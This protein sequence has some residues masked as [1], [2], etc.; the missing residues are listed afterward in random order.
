MGGTVLEH[1]WRGSSTQKC[2]PASQDRQAGRSRRGSSAEGVAWETGSQAH[3]RRQTARCWPGP[4]TVCYT[5]IARTTT[6]RVRTQELAMPTIDRRHFFQTGAAALFGAVLDDGVRHE[7]V[8]CDEDDAANDKRD[9]DR[10]VD[11]APVRCQVCKPPTCCRCYE[12]KY[13]CSDHQQYEHYCHR[14]TYCILISSNS[15]LVFAAVRK[16]A[17]C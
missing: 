4:R 7:Q 15:R 11:L 6:G 8:D 2:G 12:M 10:Q 9:V 5:C 16:T 3:T 1:E 17:G 14:L 13:Q